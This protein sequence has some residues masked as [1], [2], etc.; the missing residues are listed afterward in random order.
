MFSYKSGDFPGLKLHFWSGEN[1]RLINLASYICD[2]CFLFP[3]INT[4]NFKKRM[5]I[6]GDKFE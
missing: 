2:L 5:W 4:G 6:F 1:N 3:F